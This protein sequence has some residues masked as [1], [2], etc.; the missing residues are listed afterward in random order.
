MRKNSAF[1]SPVRSSTSSTNRFSYSLRRIFTSLVLTLFR[2][3]YMLPHLCCC[4]FDRENVRAQLVRANTHPLER[5]NFHY[6]FGRNFFVSID[7]VPDPWL[8]HSESSCQ[9]CLASDLIDRKNKIIVWTHFLTPFVYKRAINITIVFYSV[10]YRRSFSSNYICF[11]ICL[12]VARK[13][14]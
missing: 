6:I 10:N 1:S 4:L 13:E 7:P 12:I 2:S 9:F 5:Y 8:N 3:L 14:M 11:T